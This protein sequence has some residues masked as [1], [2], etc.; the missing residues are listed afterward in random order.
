M[1]A[2]VCSLGRKARANGQEKG[3]RKAG[4]EAEPIR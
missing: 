1:V 3:G 4:K 2:A